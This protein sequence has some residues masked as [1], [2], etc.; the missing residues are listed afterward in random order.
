MTMTLKEYAD[1]K[2]AAAG[3]KK[4]PSSI[5]K[6]WQER[7]MVRG[8]HEMGASGA[9]QYLSDYGRGMGAPKAINLARQAEAQGYPDMARVFWV[10]AYELEHGHAPPSDD[11][12]EPSPSAPS[13]GGASQELPQVDGLP[14]H[15]Q[16]GHLSTMQPVDAPEKR[17]AYIG[18]STYWGQ[19]KRNGHR[20]LAIATPNAVHYQSRSLNLRPSP[21]VEMDDMLQEAAREFGPFVL[22]SELYYPDVL[23]GEHRTGAEA[24]E[25]NVASGFADIHPKPKL[26]VFK[27]LFAHGKDLTP[28]AESVRIAAGEVIGRWLA[29]R[30]PDHFE[31]LPTARTAAEKR[32]LARRQLEEGR[33]G[34]VWVQHA[35]AYTPGKRKGRRPPIVRTKYL[36][37]LPAIVLSLTPTTAEGRPFGAAEVGV[38]RDGEL[39]S[40]GAIGTGF[41][42]DE[43]R[44][45]AQRHDEAPGTVV[46][47]ITTQGFTTKGK[48]MHGR[49]ECF[50]SQMPEAC[51]LE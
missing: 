4:I 14:D 11:A 42:Q 21:A 47:E 41:T 1:A 23:R 34:E 13:D 5:R 16:P 49:F 12:G 45:L 27:A 40:L 38:Y 19:P 46:I 22:D 31:V 30:E 17:G 15:L 2:R 9:R 39:V 35:C 51:V 18:D 20:F 48:V 36:D 24:A 29:E 32:D 28:E 37:R 6:R 10:M 8:L 44:E 25:V 26:A 33:E 43:M 3:S 7:V 50:S